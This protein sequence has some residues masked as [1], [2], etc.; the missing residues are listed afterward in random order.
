[1]SHWRLRLAHRA[2]PLSMQKKDNLCLFPNSELS[3]SFPHS[4]LCCLFYF[5]LYLRPVWGPLIVSSCMADPFPQCLRS[6]A[7]PQYSSQRAKPANSTPAGLAFVLAPQT[8]FHVQAKVFAPQCAYQTTHLSTCS[9][10]RCVY[11]RLFSELPGHGK[12]LC[13]PFPPWPETVDNGRGSFKKRY[14][15]MAW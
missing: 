5:L 3:V 13:G 15:A 12:L 7:S 4:S 10:V 2:F 14:R 11:N 1:M 9:P 8:L 6:H